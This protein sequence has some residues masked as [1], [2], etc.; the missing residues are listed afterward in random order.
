M[1]RF[2]LFRKLFGIGRAEAKTERIL[3]SI[4]SEFTEFAGDT[5][6]G[7]SALDTY[8]KMMRDAQVEGA[9]QQVVA[10]VIGGRVWVECDESQE[11]ADW[12]TG[13]L[14][15]I[16]GSPLDM[17]QAALMLLPYGFSVQEVVWREY[18]GKWEPHRIIERAAQKCSWDWDSKSNQ[19]ALKTSTGY[20]ATE[21]P[22][23]KYL[24]C[25]NG[26][27]TENP[28]GNSI[29]KSCYK[30][31]YSKLAIIKLLNVFLERNATPIRW[32]KP[33]FPQSADSDNKVLEM[34]ET[35]GQTSSMVVPSTYDLNVLFST[36]P[37]A[38]GQFRGAL[39]Y[40]D[41]QIAR[42]ILSESLTLEE[43]GVG[44]RS[45][46][47]SAAHQTVL[48]A[49][50]AMLRRKV[51]SAI[52]EQLVQ[53]MVQ[54]NFGEDAPQARFMIAE[55]PVENLMEYSAAIKNFVEAGVFTGQEPWIPDRVGLGNA[56]PDLEEK[57]LA[58]QQ[59][60][61]PQFPADGVNLGGGKNGRSP[62]V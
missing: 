12:A 11:I 31:W 19:W 51:A 52:N 26:N 30:N 60:A 49:K 50:G 6:T 41:S 44:A 56:N 47:Q 24:I 7:V 14:E 32:A 18:K 45:Y 27:N 13:A 25:R 39:G 16:E 15:R 37:N 17:V 58:K 59:A 36:S 57:L 9:Y 62:E 2:D 34:L 29:L 10:S 40:H 55:P 38:E 48:R 8:A 20:N 46:G 22:V 35:L 53:P 23:G 28:Y 5:L 1:P 61:V 43:G 4:F 33:Q 3:Q 42:A 21:A 54:L